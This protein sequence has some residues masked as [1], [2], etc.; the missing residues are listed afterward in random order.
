MW[1]NETRAQTMMETYPLAACQD[2]LLGEYQQVLHWT[3]KDK[4]S[5]SLL[6][7]ILSIPMF[8]LVALAFSVLAITIGRLPDNLKFGVV[9][10]G[11]VLASL[12]ATVI[13]HE[14]L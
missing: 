7:Q 8:I 4:A 6:L 10:T 12:V 1:S 14:W 3:V 9:E 2:A 5:R 11:T 13:L